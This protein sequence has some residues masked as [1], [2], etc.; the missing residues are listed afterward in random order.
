MTNRLPIVNPLAV[1]REIENLPVANDTRVFEGGFSDDHSAWLGT[2]T[3]DA[4]L[5]YCPHSWLDADGWLFIAPP[6]D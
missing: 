1:T 6:Q 4:S 2:G 5:G 3:R